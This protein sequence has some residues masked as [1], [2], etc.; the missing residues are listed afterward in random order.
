MH[1]YLGHLLTAGKDKQSNYSSKPLTIRPGAT[2]NSALDEEDTILLAGGF[3]GIHPD[4]SCT[5][6]P[7]LQLNGDLTTIS[8]TDSNA[9]ALAELKRHSSQSYRTYMQ[10]AD[11][12]LTV[13]SSNAASLHTFTNTYGGILQIDAILTKD[14]DQDFTTGH[15]IQ[16]T[17]N[18]RGLLIHFSVKQPIDLK[19]CNYCG[20]CGFVCPEKCLNEELFLDF[21]SCTL[22]QKCTDTCTRNAIDL[23]AVEKRELQTPAL[24]LL[25]K[26]SIEL[27]ESKENIYTEND[28]PAFFE[29]IYAAEIEEVIHW[30]AASCQYS[31]RLGYG[32]RLCIDACNHQAICQNKKGVKID[33]ATC[34]ECGACLAACP[35]GA[36]QYQRFNDQQFVEYFS[37]FAFPAGSTVILGNENSLHKFWW[38]SRTKRH[39]NVFFMEYPQ[40]AALH[41][42]HLLLLFTQGAAQVIVLAAKN[43]KPSN[44]ITFTNEILHQLFN[45]EQAVQHLTDIS[46]LNTLFK[47]NGNTAFTDALLPYSPCNNRRKKLL[48]IIQFLLLHSTTQA[49]TV[50]IS[51]SKDFAELHCDETQCTGCIACVGECRTGALTTDGQNYSLSHT[52]AR[53]VSCGICVT[54]CPENALAMEPG[55]SLKDTFFNERLIAQNEPASCKGCGKIF[56][57]RKSLEKV[58]S[59]LS[60]RGMW[61]SADDL[62]EYC[63][64]CR[65]INLYK[66]N[67]HGR[68]NSAD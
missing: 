45:R 5:L 11:P 24:L 36:L 9:L 50:M 54:V 41:A 49:K 16:V 51:A 61:D 20:D 17:Q 35:T 34:L 4:S 55:L 39:A 2:F 65:V 46:C 47:Q 62:L 10:D 8:N 30:N 7:T 57:T 13:L 66:S 3:P 26:T 67:E 19:C 15:E 33:H 59:I 29:T 42:M 63:D 32:C 52:P 1:T 23:H 56:G 21:S 43:S 22:C 64:N 38:H 6:S 53:C 25:E 37:D 14:Y 68:A 27:P 18:N 60:A 40:P 58:I 28:L 44:Q 12:R 31:A 48:K